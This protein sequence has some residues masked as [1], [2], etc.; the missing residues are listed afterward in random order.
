MDYFGKPVCVAKALPCWRLRF[1]AGK[2]LSHGCSSHHFLLH[3]SSMGRTVDMHVTSADM[4]TRGTGTLKSAASERPSL[5]LVK[6]AVWKSL[7]PV[8]FK[9]WLVDTS[10]D[11]VVECLPG[12]HKALAMTRMCLVL[13][14]N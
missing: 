1:A 4:H 9:M 3:S 11:S 5:L 6:T 7:S 2:G 12:W 8:F 13:Q 14:W 10:C